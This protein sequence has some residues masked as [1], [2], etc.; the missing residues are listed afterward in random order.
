M[1]LGM[2]ACQVVALA[3]SSRGKS[4]SHSETD[5]SRNPKEGIEQLLKGYQASFWTMFA[6]MVTCGIIGI[7]GLRKI[8]KVGV[9]RD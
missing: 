7:G 3:V 1:S 2:G 9:K 6:F 8:G 4:Q 5:T